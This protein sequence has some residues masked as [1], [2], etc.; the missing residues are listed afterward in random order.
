MAHF[1]NCDPEMADQEYCIFRKPDKDEKEARKFYNKLV[2]KFFGYVLNIKGIAV[3]KLENFEYNL[4]FSKN[5]PVGG[6]TYSHRANYRFRLSLRCEKFVFPEIPTDVAFSFEYAIFEKKAN[7][8]SAIF[9]GYTTFEGAVFKNEAIFDSAI[10]KGNTI[11]EKAQFNGVSRFSDATFEMSAYFENSM[12][13]GNAV[14]ERTE[15]R[16][17]TY[18]ENATFDKTANFEETMFFGKS[19]FQKCRF[20]GD[21]KFSEACFE[22]SSDFERCI[23]EKNADFS[24][25]TFNGYVYFDKTIFKGDCL[26]EGV[27]FNEPVSLKGKPKEYEY[28][29]YGKLDFSNVDIRKGISIIDYKEDGSLYEEGF[30]SLFKRTDALIEAARVQRLSFEKEGKREEADRMFVIEMRAK[31]KLRKLELFNRALN[32]ALNVRVIKYLLNLS[33]KGTGWM[34][35]DSE[36]LLEFLKLILLTFTI[37]PLTALVVTFAILLISTL[38]VLGYVTEVVIGDWVSLYGT[39]WERVLES[40]LIVILGSTLL[41]WLGQKAGFGTVCIHSTVTSNGVVCNAPISSFWDALYYS[42]VTFTTLGYGDMHPTGWL[43]ALS[44]IEALTGAVFMA[45]IVAVIARK[46]MR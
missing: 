17:E 28:K 3:R 43:K 11:F 7:F 6:T 2:L 19:N 39:S 24:A 8:R 36:S 10:F 27:T 25:T 41:Y 18:F 1:G 34:R 13:N 31:R 5:I 46:W 42:L 33:E 23:F 20:L 44:A 21:A 30:L 45:L 12:F 4:H 32:R 16:R 9:I 38:Y 14:F 40:S 15:F 37:Y 35:K 22:L 29:F 26:F